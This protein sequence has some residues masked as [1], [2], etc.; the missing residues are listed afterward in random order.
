MKCYCLGKKEGRLVNL[1][2][3]LL[4]VYPNELKPYVH[5]R[6]CTRMFIAAL[7]TVVKT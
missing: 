4:G 6:T 5:K 1:A 3:M 7:F 2:I